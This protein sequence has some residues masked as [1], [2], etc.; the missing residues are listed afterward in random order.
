MGGIITKR[1]GFLLFIQLCDRS[2]DG[3]MVVTPVSE[4]VDKIK[5]VKQRTLTQIIGIPN[6]K[7]NPNPEKN[8]DT[9][10]VIPLLCNSI[11]S[12]AT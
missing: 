9:D 5:C 4:F 11:S 12:L 7:S 8:T 6:S 3:P 10:F 2:Y 1:R